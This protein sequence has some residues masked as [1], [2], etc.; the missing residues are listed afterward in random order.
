MSDLVEEPEEGT[1]ELHRFGGTFP[2]GLGIYPTKGEVVND[3]GAA[4][5]L[6]D[7]SQW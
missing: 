4:I 6:R 2:D 7:D 3:S 5:A 1:T